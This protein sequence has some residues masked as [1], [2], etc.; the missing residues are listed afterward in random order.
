MEKFIQYYVEN[1]LT[2]LEIFKC[3]SMDATHPL[4]SSMVLRS[5]E[6]KKDEFGPCDEGDGCLG[7]VAAYLIAIVAL[8]Y[9]G[10]YN[11]PDFAFVVN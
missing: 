9:F 8:M 4:S 7:P 2:N 1:I 5:L 6:L 10:S 11:K 3:L